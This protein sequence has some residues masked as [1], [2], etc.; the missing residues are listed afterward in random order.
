MNAFTKFPD[1]TRTLMDT[2]SCK[3]DAHFW[4]CDAYTDHTEAGGAKVLL[5]G[6]R[7]S[8]VGPEGSFEINGSEQMLAVIE[9]LQS[10]RKAL[11]K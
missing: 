3:A 9:M 11:R 6:D 7:V 8:L 10:A 2:G 5:E 4:G 1:T